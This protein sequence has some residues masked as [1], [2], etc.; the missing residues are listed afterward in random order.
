MTT[1]VTEPGTAD[2]TNTPAIYF[3]ANDNR[4][5]VCWELLQSGRYDNSGDPALRKVLRKEIVLFG[6][7]YNFFCSFSNPLE[8]IYLES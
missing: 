7:E 3:E 1:P 6:D 2:A 5:D 4:R 8:C